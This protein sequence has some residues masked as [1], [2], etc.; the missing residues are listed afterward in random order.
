MSSA[1]G[2]PGGGGRRRAIKVGLISLLFLGTGVYFLV[3]AKGSPIETLDARVTAS[4]ATVTRGDQV[5]FEFED[6]SYDVMISP[7]AEGFFDAV[8]EFGPG[9]ARVT[10]NATNDSIY[11]VEFRRKR[12][13]FGSPGGDRGTGIVAVVLGVL[14]L[15]YAG[16]ISFG[17]PKAA[18]GT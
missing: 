5:D 10:R 17:A 16:L 6:G 3:T 1:T 7:T 13:E 9:P 8:E 11:E 4:I 18:E 12:Y 2:G 14:G 15:G